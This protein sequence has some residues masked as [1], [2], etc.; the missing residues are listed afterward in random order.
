MG[1]SPECSESN[2]S[3]NL[4]VSGGVSPYTF[5][6]GVSTEEDPTLHPNKAVVLQSLNMRAKAQLRRVAVPLSKSHQRERKTRRE[7]IVHTSTT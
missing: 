6:W 1:R 3:I 7:M 5:D 2:G 4:T